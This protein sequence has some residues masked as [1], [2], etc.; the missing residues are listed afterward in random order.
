MSL[1]FLEIFKR[2]LP[3][4]SSNLVRLVPVNRKDYPGSSPFTPEEIARLASE[5]IQTREAA[6]RAL[7]MEFGAFFAWFVQTYQTPPIVSTGT[8]G[9]AGGIIVVS[10]SLAHATLGPMI[11]YPDSLLE[12]TGTLLSTHLRAYCTLGEL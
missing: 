11:A 1:W 9:R 8:G 4:A 2:M 3:Y 10:W 7:A 5:D 6:V 12:E